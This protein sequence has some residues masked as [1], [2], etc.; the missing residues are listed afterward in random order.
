MLSKIQ[1]S[2]IYLGDYGWHAGRFHFSFAEYCDPENLSFG[3]L[4][5]FNDFTLQPGTGFD[6]H[7]H[8]EI[9]IVSYCVNGQLVHEDSLG[10]KEILQHGEMQYTCAGSGITHSESN[11]SLK[12]PLRFIQV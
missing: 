9:E 8:E 7:P 11:A 1:A 3:N 2:Q 12:E 10:N 5:T 6:K 4:M